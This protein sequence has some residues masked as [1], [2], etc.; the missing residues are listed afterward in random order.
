MYV[1]EGITLTKRQSARLI[2]TIDIKTYFYLSAQNQLCTMQLLHKKVKHY[3]IQKDQILFITEAA[4]CANSLLRCSH[5][6]W[7]QSVSQ[8]HSKLFII[9][10]TRHP[11][12]L[13]DLFPL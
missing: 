4:T 5:C 7:S 12:L 10:K 11:K 8:T 2:R 13:L 3:I 1:H 6:H 9:S